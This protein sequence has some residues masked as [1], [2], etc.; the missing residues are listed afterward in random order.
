MEQQDFDRVAT[1][2]QEMKALKEDAERRGLPITG[3]SLRDSTY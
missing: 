3:S 1:L 2:A